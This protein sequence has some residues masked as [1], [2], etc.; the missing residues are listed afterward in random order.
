MIC[1]N[2][3]GRGIIEIEQKCPTCNG[4]GKA[5]SFDPKLTEELSS[6][7]IQLFLRGICGVCRGE[8]VIKRM[9][10]CPVCRGSREVRRCKLCGKPVKGNFDLCQDCSKK[11]HAYLLKNSCGIEDLKLNK[12]YVA[13]VESVTDIGVFAN[14]NKRL[15]GLIYKRNLGNSNFSE[16]EQ[17]TVKVAGIKPSGEIDLLPYPM[18]NYSIVEIAKR[19]PRVDI[20]ELDEYGG[21]LVEIRGLVTHIRVTGGPTI[22]SIVD[23]SGVGKAVAFEGGERAFPEIDVDDVVAITGIV[24]KRPKAEI[25][26][27]DMERL[28]GEEATEIRKVIEEEID[29]RSEPEFRGFLVETEVLENLKSEMMRVAK[30]LKRAIFQSRPIIIRHHWDADGMCGGLALE[31]ALSALVEEVA[32]PE[33]KYILV[34]RKVSRAP[35]YE[36]EDVVKDLDD[37]LED[38][39]RH[40][41][42]IPLVV[43]VDNG[44]GYEDIP[45]IR[46][47]LTFGADIITIDHHF[48]DEEVDQY[49]LYH[50]NPYKAGGDSNHTS[51]ILCT[52]I[53][54][55]IYPEIDLRNLPAIS[56]VGDRAEGEVEEYLRLSDYSIQELRDIA[57]ALEYE[58]FYLRFRSGSEI[59]KEIM[60]FGRKDRQAK[61]VS[62]LASYARAGIEEQLKTIQEGYRVQMLPNGIY[63]A[64]LDIENYTRRFTFPPPGKLTGELH[65][66]LKNKYEKLVTIGYGPDF[67]V[68]RSEGV[69]L[70]IPRLVRE[71][72]Q[73][74]ENAGVEGGGHLVVGSIK[75][76]PAKR[77]EVLAKLAAK[78]GTI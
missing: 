54:R 19:A 24:K 10:I 70:D 42:K 68:I 49:L 33:S 48:P 37:S 25:E 69:E 47:F 8:G 62:M 1:E 59:I 21:K 41:D 9:E 65:D 32:D 34:K 57:L 52:E 60:G 11:P 46:Q 15:R 76:I 53:A 20:S 4:S 35:F 39:I 45:A 66:R 36:L 74:I 17:I 6:E 26:I 31:L 44:S 18:D 30:E 72:Q 5:R 12:I 77:K 71:L 3:G 27:L 75:F 67:A 28:L 73:E 55:M 13:T 23:G 64:A 16:G 38:A 58:A 63:L 7:Q 14:L 43:L 51:G 40:G 29:R 22:F 78:I 50:V 61:L 2:C 56:I